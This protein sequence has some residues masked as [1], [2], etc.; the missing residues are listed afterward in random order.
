MYNYVCTV[1]KIKLQEDHLLCLEHLDT[2]IQ[3][4]TH[5]KKAITIKHNAMWI[6]EFTS[7]PPFFAE[8]GQK[9]TRQLEYSNTMV[10]TDQYIYTV[11]GNVYSLRAVKLPWP[12]LQIKLPEVEVVEV[13]DLNSVVHSTHVVVMSCLLSNISYGIVRHCWL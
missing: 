13:K 9:F 12:T 4:V 7:S 11:V 5:I 6:T 2:S 3:P 8:G 1:M 10:S